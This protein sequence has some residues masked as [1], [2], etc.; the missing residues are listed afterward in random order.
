M[1]FDMKKREKFR[2]YLRFCEEKDKV[3]T[4]KSFDLCFKWDTPI[5][6]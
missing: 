2:G 3:R 1:S 6:F 5:M 4:P